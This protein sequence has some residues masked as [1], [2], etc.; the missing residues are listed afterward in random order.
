MRRL[1]ADGVDG[2]RHAPCVVDVVVPGRGWWSGSSGAMVRCVVARCPERAMVVV[3]VKR[4]LV[5]G[6]LIERLMVMVVWECYDDWSAIDN[7]RLAYPV[8]CAMRVCAA[9][10]ADDAADEV[11]RWWG[12]GEQQSGAGD[13]RQ[14]EQEVDGGGRGRCE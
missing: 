8:A 12:K 14:L 4:E 13:G 7:E 11:E 6:M 2:D 1:V 5:S 10:M 9:A 3:V